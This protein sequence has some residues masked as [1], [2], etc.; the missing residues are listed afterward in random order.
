MQSVGSKWL[1]EATSIDF[2]GYAVVVTVIVPR[3]KGRVPPAPASSVAA[4]FQE[5][6]TRFEPASWH[7]THFDTMSGEAW[8]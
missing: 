5:A 3:V 4:P 2:P 7:E 6:P 1:G 8:S